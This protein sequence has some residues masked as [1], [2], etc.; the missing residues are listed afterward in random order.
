MHDYNWIKIQLT[1][2]SWIKLLSSMAIVFLKI[3]YVEKDK[4]CYCIFLMILPL[5]FWTD[6]MFNK[7]EKHPFK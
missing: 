3:F 1:P 5:S 4:G 2:V 7:Q 6:R